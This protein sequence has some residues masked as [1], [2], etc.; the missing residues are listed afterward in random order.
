[1]RQKAIYYYFQRIKFI[2]I[3]YKKMIKKIVRIHTSNEDLEDIN[4]I[5][6]NIMN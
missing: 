2:K 6:E 5:R 1:M 3:G 4:M